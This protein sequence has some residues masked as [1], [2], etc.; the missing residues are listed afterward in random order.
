[1]IEEGTF[2][3]DLFYRL[4]IVPIYLPPLRKRR[5]DIPL[6]INH[7]L[8]KYNKKRNKNIKG[9]SPEAMNLLMDFEW[10]GNIRELENIVER[11]V[12]MSEGET[13][14]A[15]HVPMYIRGKEVYMKI[16]TPRTNE[17]FK[18]MKK[19][20][21]AKAIENVERAFVIDVLRRNDW[22]VSKAAR[23]IGVKRQNLQSLIRKYN[24]KQ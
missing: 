15:S 19:Q 23:D 11:L 2:R 9:V 12:I 14:E 16:T 24:I 18:K 3:E 13:I 22:N 21:R 10:P 5:E 4:N 20:I 8:E 6:L 7:F 1:M 17:E